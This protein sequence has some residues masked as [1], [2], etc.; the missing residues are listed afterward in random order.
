MHGK[1]VTAITLR[2]EEFDGALAVVYTDNGCGIEEADKEKIFLE[3][4]GRNTGL[5]LYLIR[6]ILA[7]NQIS[8]VENGEPGK[9][10]QFVIRVPRGLYQK[11]SG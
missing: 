11:K 1:T 2:A 5:G 6:E 9:G 10:A 8:I 4:Y 3:G 7:A